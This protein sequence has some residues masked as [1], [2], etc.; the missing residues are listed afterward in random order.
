[1][2][3]EYTNVKIFESIL[4]LPNKT[5]GTLFIYKRPKNEPKALKPDGY[6]FADGVTFILDA[7]AQGKKFSG[8]LEDY[9]LLEKNKNKIGFKYSFDKF[10]C[11]INDKKQ[12]DEVNLQNYQYYLDKYFPKKNTNQEIVE[13]SA[14]KLSIMF[15]NSKINKQI[16]VPFIG[17][18]MLCLKFEKNILNNST[19]GI[20]SLIRQGI[21]EVISDTPITRKQKKEFL[22]NI[23]SDSSLIYS[24]FEYIFP[25]I[26]EI[27]TVFNFINVS[28]KLGHDT[29]NLF[30]KIF[31]K[32]NSANAN[33]KGEVF[34]PDHIAQFMYKLINISKYDIVLDPTCG[35]G[36]FLTN[37]MANMLEE[38]I[39]ENEKNNIKENQLIGIECDGFNATLAGIN[40]MLH[41]DGASQIYMDDCFK[42]LPH[43]K[44][45]YNKVLMNPPFSQDVPEL[46][47]VLE[48]LNNM[49][50]DGMLASILPISCALGRKWN[51]L[52]KEILENHQLIQTVR[53]PKDLFFPNASIDTCILVFKAWN[54][55]KGKHKI[56]KSDF[57]DD[58][59]TYKMRVGRVNK[60]N[61]EKTNSFFNENIKIFRLV[62]YKDDW[63]VEPIFEYIKINISDFH[64]AKIDFFKSKWDYNLLSSVRNN[65]ISNINP[66]VLEID[67]CINSWK[68]FKISELFSY[69]DK[70]KDKINKKINDSKTPCVNAKKDNN[71]IGGYVNEPNKIF[72]RNKLTVV[73]QGDGGA[74]MTY[75]QDIDFCATASVF[76]L[77]PIFS[78]D[79][80]VGVFI[81]KICSLV[82]KPKYSHG[83]TLNKRTLLNEE[84]KIPA[85]NDGNPNWKFIKKLMNF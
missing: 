24:K 4:G 42:K 26:S 7:K 3:N 77:K 23:L 13:K 79:V 48:T 75:F 43:L 84:I 47:F 59:F 72:S 19:K 76:V 44:N 35:S 16:N 10:E 58:G 51:E 74:G 60:N 55:I 50:K 69:E 78:F 71:G 70:G 33:E 68:T 20:L 63:L 12:I 61:E 41:G 81:A 45:E 25:I 64:K 15:R 54:K 37:S 34:T 36:T 52:R 2:Q 57:S 17:A 65:Y 73:S 82:F 14:K 62:D 1:M 21:S 11:W 28:N 56:I 49:K 67:L 6:F 27:S 66:F 39:D 40:M 8:Q 9:L 18:V 46:K 80:S 83:K 30:L 32:W 85:D 22:K 5:D 53:L 38:T 31:R 29:M